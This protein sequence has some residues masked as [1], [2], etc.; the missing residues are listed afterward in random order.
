VTTGSVRIYVEKVGGAQTTIGVVGPYQ[1][2]GEMALLD[3]GARAASAQTIE[4]VTMLSIDRTGWLELL[5]HHPTLVRHVLH[6]LG[7]SARRYA[8]EAVECL[9]LDLEGRMARLL[10]QLAER[11]GASDAPMQLDV[12]LTQ[13]ELA[14][15]VRG[16][17]QSVNQVLRRLEAAGYLRSEHGKI[18]ITDREGL[19]ARAA[20]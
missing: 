20:S 6:T 7:A 16:S 12:R 19:W 14:N 15:M 13:G 3:A 5:E 10:L 18:I 2:F 9:F 4:P 17:R 8:N 1:T 11:H